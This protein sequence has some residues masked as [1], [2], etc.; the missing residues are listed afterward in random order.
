MAKTKIN[1][2]ADAMVE[3]A[4]DMHRAGIMDD[5]GLAKI[6]ARHLGDGPLPTAV[7]MSADEIREVRERSHLSQ[8]VFARYLNVSTGYVSQLER[9]TRAPKGAALA[10]LNV[11]R[12]KGIEALQ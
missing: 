12:F 9:G 1:P 11:I 5:A 2:M 7:P 6:T 8:A 3:T 4:Q 10:L